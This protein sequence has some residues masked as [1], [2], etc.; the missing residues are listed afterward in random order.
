MMVIPDCVTP[1]TDL[2][3]HVACARGLC[4]S[5]GDLLAEIGGGDD[6]LSQGDTVVLQEHALQ[7]FADDG[8]VVD[9][10]CHVVEE[11]DD[12]LGHVVAR[13]SLE[14]RGVLHKMADILWFEFFD[15]STASIPRE[16]GP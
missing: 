1:L 12:Q 4:T 16:V 13:G 3:L 7:T 10:A 11:L 15:A 9:H 2:E 14:R 8:V 5:S 6:L